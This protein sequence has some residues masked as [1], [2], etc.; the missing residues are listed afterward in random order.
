MDRLL[1]KV[2][3]DTLTRAEK[4]FL[5]EVLIAKIKNSATFRKEY[6][7]SHLEK[8]KRAESNAGG[9]RFEGIIKNTFGD[10][11]WNEYQIQK[12]NQSE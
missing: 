1:E 12:K 4:L 10:E 2:N 8:W 3:T 7:Q 6:V 11:T 5:G 9:S